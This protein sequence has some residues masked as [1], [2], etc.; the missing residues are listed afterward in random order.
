[1][2]KKGRPLSGSDC[3]GIPL[4]DSFLRSASQTRLDSSRLRHAP[5]TGPQKTL[6][7]RLEQNG[8]QKSKT[9]KQCSLSFLCC[10]SHQS[11]VVT[12]TAL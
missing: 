2:Q 6:K 4:L 12:A 5:P 9:S 10:L 11:I 3:I 8:F 7:L 1:M